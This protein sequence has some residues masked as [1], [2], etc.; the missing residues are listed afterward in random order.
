MTPAIL[1]QT[2][3]DAQLDKTWL[4]DVITPYLG[5]FFVAFF[6]A[7]TVTPLMRL[8]A[9]RNGIVD[10]PDL[11]RKDHI[12]PVAYL[13]GVAIFLGWLAGMALCFFRRPSSETVAA[14]DLGSVI[15]IILGAIAIT[16]TGL[17]DDVFHIS[18]RVKVG[19]QLFA[20]AALASQDVG[21]RLVESTLTIFGMEGV[22]Q[23]IVYTLGT[24][25][26]A[27]FV[28]GGC[29][30][31]NLLDGLD[32]LAAGVGT[33]ANIGFL[34]I[35]ALVAVRAWMAGAPGGD[36]LIGDAERIVMCLAMVGA[37]LGF[38]PY[39][40]SPATIFM[41]DAGSL[42]LG[43]LCA[44]TILLFTGTTGTGVLLVAACLIVFAVPIIDTML[45]IF[46]RKLAGRPVFSPD[47]CHIHHMLRQAGLSVKQTVL[48]LYAASALFA[49]IGC[50][51]VALRVGPYILAVFVVLFGFVMVTAYKYGQR[52]VL[53][54][55]VLASG[56]EGPEGPD[57]PKATVGPTG[58]AATADQGEVPTN[59][60]SRQPT[61]NPDGSR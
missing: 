12:Q 54:E 23:P 53:L 47:T 32:G 36:G 24:I 19:G 55:Q 51:M 26:I 15:A 5:V 35:A 6:V 52:Q 46:R 29:N 38:L 1:A 27:V 33:I 3:A 30:A 17:F 61:G 25:V 2:A 34:I 10:W 4:R 49:A 14:L 28:I 22:P 39:N 56:P 44:T 48:V 42:L 11:K 16:L 41:G 43:Y 58:D 50:T 18:P 59:A 37:M 57:E 13:G 45:A 31:M 20:A 7:F 40:F 8:L 21:I 9:V 60:K